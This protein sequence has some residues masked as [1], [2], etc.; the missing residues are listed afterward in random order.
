M[1]SQKA[2]NVQKKILQLIE[3]EYSGIPLDESV[4]LL[5]D[6][7][8]GIVRAGLEPEPAQLV[9]VVEISPEQQADIIEIAKEPPAIDRDDYSFAEKMENEVVKRINKMDDEPKQSFKNRKKKAVAV[10][11]FN[12][13]RRLD[14][15]DLF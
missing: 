4:I 9:E 5:S 7:I 8:S 2:K 15:D 10:E 14:D 3:A 11:E 13:I 12:D 6:L 1:D